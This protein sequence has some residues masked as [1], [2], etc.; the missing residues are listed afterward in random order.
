MDRSKSASPS[1]NSAENEEGPIASSSLSSTSNKSGPLSPFACLICSKI[2]SAVRDWQAFRKMDRKTN[3]Q[4][5]SRESIK[6]AAQYCQTCAKLNSKFASS[7]ARYC[8]ECGVTISFGWDKLVFTNNYKHQHGIIKATLLPSQ[9]ID[10]EHQHYTRPNTE[11]IDLAQV[12]S[13]ISRCDSEHGPDC[14]ADHKRSPIHQLF[15]IDV[16]DLCIVANNSRVKF[17]ALS[18]VWGK[19]Q[20]PFQ[21]LKSNK[22]E[23]CQPGSFLRRWN[24]LPRTV[25]DAILLSKR[26]QVRYIW[27][28]RFCIVQDDAD[29]I[30]ENI[31]AMA[32]IYSQSYFTIVAADGSDPE[33]GLCGI[34]SDSGPRAFQEELR[35]DVLAFEDLEFLLD[36]CAAE[37]N[38]AWHSRAWTYQERLVS[39]RCL[40]FNR[41]MVQ[42]RCQSGYF[43]EKL[44]LFESSE[45]SRG[46]LNIF[47]PSRS[48]HGGFTKAYSSRALTKQS[49]APKA[50]SII[51][52]S[53]TPSF[54]GGFI[55]GMPVF[56]LDSALDWTHMGVGIRREGI[57]S[58]SFLGWQG[59]IEVNGF[60]A[61]SIEGR[62]LNIPIG[63]WK[64]KDSKTKEL[65][66]IKLDHYEYEKYENEETMEPPKSWERVWISDGW[67]K[68]PKPEY[69]YTPMI[70]DDRKY[71]ASFPHP[72]PITPLDPIPAVA[73]DGQ[74]LYVTTQKALF[75]LGEPV[76]PMDYHLHKPIAALL[77]DIS[78]HRVAGII[79]TNFEQRSEYVV[80]QECLLIALYHGQT[81]NTRW[82]YPGEYRQFD[83]DMET[84]ESSNSNSTTWDWI[85]VL[86]VELKKGI[87]YRRGTGRVWARAWASAEVTIS[88][89]TLG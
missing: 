20:S 2:S 18:Y 21:T 61:S 82:I 23:L 47:W 13:W 43:H 87:A 81:N 42:L 73:M 48:L 66:E 32:S 74:Y 17:T 24:Q 6:A 29:S 37:S 26:L 14:H 22:E 58:W 86:W 75:T 52:E 12:Q 78:T 71:L 50:F 72:M 34:G 8:D 49:D 46:F 28:D 25:Q 60:W 59:P 44:G 19:A 85:Q 55:W 51:T 64:I 79:E 89:I 16:H 39:R 35:S 84:K 40:V 11:N 27:I 53:L 56:Y 3:I 9:A 38:Q 63:M 62:L 31:N 45:G 83:D 88:D 57:P 7:S 67:S 5:A 54:P 70:G 68:K 77:H 80:G 1:T 65:V 10:S 15:F 69:R 76:E 33:F 30:S 4:I 41:G 36:G